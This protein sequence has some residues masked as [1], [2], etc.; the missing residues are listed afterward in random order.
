MK[1][2]H[3]KCLRENA[4]KHT[5]QPKGSTRPGGKNFNHISLA[6]VSGASPAFSSPPKYVA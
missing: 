5:L 4:V 6:S 2:F 3:P 1:I